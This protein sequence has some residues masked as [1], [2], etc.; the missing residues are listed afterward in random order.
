MAEQKTLINLFLT[1][2]EKYPDR[3]LMWE[4][5][6]GEYKATTYHEA[7]SVVEKIAAGLM[8]LDLRLGDRVVLFAPGRND[9]VSSELAILFCG[10]INVPLSI[11]LKEL[12]ELKFR[13]EHSKT[14]FAIV[15]QPQLDAV[16]AIKND[17]PALEKI[18]SLDE[19]EIEDTDLLLMKDLKKM[20]EDFLAKKRAEFETRFQSV[21]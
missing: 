3:P 17:L 21:Q 20:G 4:K 2:V 18:I 13:F 14:R 6:D 15:A 8:E 12:N 10:A 5:Q 19:V 1:S 11:K 16:L 9:W 7:K